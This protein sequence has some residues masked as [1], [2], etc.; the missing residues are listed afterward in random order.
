MFEQLLEAARKLDDASLLVATPELLLEGMHMDN[1][2]PTHFTLSLIML[3]QHITA[4]PDNVTFKDIVGL[5]TEARDGADTTAVL[6]AVYA[7]LKSIKLPTPSDSAGVPSC[8]VLGDIAVQVGQMMEPVCAGA[9]YDEDSTDYASLS[10]NGL[11]G[12]HILARL[13][14]FRP[15]ALCS[16]LLLPTNALISI[17]A[18]THRDD[19]WT[20]D[21]SPE[22]A[23]FFLSD[24]FSRPIRE[25][26]DGGGG[27]GNKSSTTTL[28]TEL[29]RFIL[30]AVFPDF[31]RPLFAKSRPATVTASG[32]PAFFPTPPSRYGQGDGF[33]SSGNITASKPWK[34][35]KQYAVTVFGWAVENSDSDLLQAHWNSYTPILL[36]LLDEPQP[37]ALKLR[38]LSIF[39]TFWRLCPEGLLL[40]VGL[41]DVFEQAVFPTVMSLPSLTPEAESLAL[42][43]VAYP[44]LFDMAGLEASELKA[45]G[46]NDDEKKED[47][48]SDSSV[49]EEAGRTVTPRGGG[50]TEAQ[51][52]LLDK[53]VREGIMAGYH[54]A[55]EHV[56]L[57]DFFCKALCRLLD[58]MGILSV[59]YLKDIIPM[60][61]EILVDPFG[62][63]HPPTLLH[64]TQLLQVVLLTCWPRIP[65]YCNEIIRSMMLAWLNIEDDDDFPSD[66][67][68][69]AELK[70]ELT[71]TVEMLSAVAV[72]A[73]L[74]MSDRVGPLV[75]KEPKL[76]PLF[77]SC[78]AK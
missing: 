57:A 53:I 76:R 68:T 43:E 22:F 15:E 61:S 64:V 37:T 46:D 35:D 49:G 6:S 29:A 55:K 51:R 54:H 74:D 32:R 13:V 72:A 75:A 66:T 11:L 77:V 52:K 60:I 58:G 33:E 27:T 36:T 5:A 67:P 16:S 1:S 24:Y 48:R 9:S 40:R 2:P 17:I 44:A 47:T 59:K 41:V 21:S 39:Q 30:E 50:F 12:L 3:T 4:V 23:W 14:A 45:A 56:R 8:D 19:P 73:K 31:L 28:Q 34:Y 38:A 62:T 10:H 25:G 65:H 20:A 71:R 42:L 78:E 18:F 70:Q 63:K 26:R 69:K 7:A